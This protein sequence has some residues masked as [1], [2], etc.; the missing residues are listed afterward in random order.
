MI[1]S[2]RMRGKNENKKYN[3]DFLYYLLTDSTKAEIFVFGDIKF[4]FGELY[5]RRAKFVLN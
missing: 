3:P 4:C 1:L 5:K 2:N